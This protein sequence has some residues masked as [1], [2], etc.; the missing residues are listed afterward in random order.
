MSELNI[1][2]AANENFKFVKVEFNGSQKEY[3]YKTTLELEDGD[4]VVVDTPSTGLTCAIV[5]EVLRLEEVDLES[6]DY[7]WI[8]SKVDLEYY[9]KVKEMQSTVRKTINDSRRAK[10]IKNMREQISES[11]GEDTAKKV[12]KLVRL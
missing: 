8:V 3:L 6:F 5:T 7:K 12:E 10:L 2:L 11:L 1:L 9:E 4:T